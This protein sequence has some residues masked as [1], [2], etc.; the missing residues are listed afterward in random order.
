M[1]LIYDQEAHVLLQD[2]KFIN[3]WKELHNNCNYATAFQEPEFVCA[4]Y[5]AYRD[6][7]KPIILYRESSREELTDLFLLA[8]YPAT[9]SLVHAG[10]EQ[11]EY[12][13]W[14]SLPD[15]GVSFLSAAWDLL[16]SQFD[17][18]S[19]R[20]RYLPQAEPLRETLSRLPNRSSIG[21]R[22]RPRPLM[23]LNV[24]EIKAS[25]AKKSNKS[26]FNR[27][28]KLGKIEFNRVQDLIELDRVFDDLIAFYDLRQGAVNQIKPF[29]QD[30]NKRKFH[31]DLFKRAQNKVYVTVTYLN[32]KPIA[33][34]FGLASKNRA[35]LGMIMHSPFLAEHSLGKLHLMQLSELLL[36]ENMGVLD[37]TPGS[38]PWKERFANAHDE[39]I[40]AIIYR[41]PLAKIKGEMIYGLLN[42]FRQ[43]ANQVGIT[44]AKLKTILSVV[45]TF[46]PSMISGKI[47]KWF[48]ADRTF[49][50]YQIDRTF[51]ERFHRDERIR[52][53]ELDDLLLFEPRDAGQSE[54][55]FLSTA[56]ARLEKGEKVYTM[57]INNRIVYSNWMA[58]NQSD[59]KPIAF[60]PDSISIYDFFIDLDF[61]KSGIFKTAIEHL[62]CDAFVDQTIQYAFVFVPTDRKQYSKIVEEMGFSFRNSFPATR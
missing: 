54:S 52:C 34:F 28:K 3:R 50:I 45:R 58:H 22:R 15:E 38:D 10:G 51:A 57:K 35:H 39:V 19:L 26:R 27:L 4:W 16:S 17:F 62:I 20:F 49:H 11:S 5:E 60:P 2:L 33:G 1:K 44:T 55:G 40:E 30:P 46:R 9:K 24:D 41:S 21:L 42:W 32:E 25:F 61:E 12:H 18:T 8:Y 48:N 31:I 53:N 43:R 36:N 13:A 6:L 37:L 7:W 47:G 56:L 59:K 23:I 14:L 29:Q